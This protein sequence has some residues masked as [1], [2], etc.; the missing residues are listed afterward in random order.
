VLAP[1]RNRRLLP[2]VVAS[3]LAF[4]ALDAAG[5][6][7]IAAVRRTV[8][9][10]GQP[11]G[12][13]LGVVVAPLANTWNGAV[14]YD[15]LADENRQLRRRVAEL[16]G[17]SAGQADLEA[18]IRSLLEATEIEYL[19]DVERVTARVVSDRRT[20]IERVVEIDK[21]SEAGIELGMP[22]VTGHGLAGMVELVTGKRSVVRLI[23]DADV[24]VGVR[25]SNGLGLTDGRGDGGL[26]LRATPELLEAIRLGAVTDGERFVTS[27]VDRS[28]YP[29]GI[30]VGTLSVGP[31][32]A[33][34]SRVGD[35]RP[36]EDLDGPPGPPPGPASPAGPVLAPEDVTYEALGVLEVSLQPLA[37]IDRLGYLTVLLVEPP[38]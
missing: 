6:G 18:D 35:P 7:P 29:P 1:G 38:A 19:G 2:L 11:I 8:L 34:P 36:G 30:P 3:A 5:F 23:T 31:G 14:H 33:E 10:V 37:D 21:G 25:S 16:E 26:G 27:G 24:S 32:A 22:V 12:A 17:R 13:V 4:L 15:E 20:E 9:S 28:L